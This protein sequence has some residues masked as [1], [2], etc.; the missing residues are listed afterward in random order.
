MPTEDAVGGQAGTPAAS[1]GA[2]ASASMALASSSATTAT[3]PV[4]TGAH[5]YQTPISQGAS[6]SAAFGGVATI[7]T[8][9]WSTTGTPRGE[10]PRGGSVGAGAIAPISG[11]GTPRSGVA[12][13]SCGGTPRNDAAASEASTAGGQGVTAP[14]AS[15]ASTSQRSALPPPPLPA[16]SAP[17]YLKNLWRS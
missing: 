6:F 16:T 9:S 8:G 10:I 3:A 1:T 13:L 11:E 17:R 2:A 15:V 12:E 7:S 4:S 14:A 5:G